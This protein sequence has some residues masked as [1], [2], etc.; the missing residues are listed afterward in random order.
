MV[1]PGLFPGCFVGIGSR[2][3]PKAVLKLGTPGVLDPVTG[4]DYRALGIH[5]LPNPGFAKGTGI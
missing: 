5:P 4:T 2:N 1:F 3:R